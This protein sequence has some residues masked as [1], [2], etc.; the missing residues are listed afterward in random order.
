MIRDKCL[1][2]NM[3]SAVKENF[4]VA[5]A[6]VVNKIEVVQKYAVLSWIVF[7]GSID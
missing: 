7:K 1:I 5:R 2:S 4:H 6:I 3:I